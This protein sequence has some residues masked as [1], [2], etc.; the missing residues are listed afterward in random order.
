MFPAS[1]WCGGEVEEAAHGTLRDSCWD[2]AGRCDTLLVCSCACASPACRN[3]R[4]QNP[5]QNIYRDSYWYKCAHPHC[6]IRPAD[7]YLVCGDSNSFPQG[8]NEVTGP[9]RDNN[10]PL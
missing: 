4:Q 6:K 1:N 3:M 7:G 5:K 8:Q 10:S 9:R 2:R